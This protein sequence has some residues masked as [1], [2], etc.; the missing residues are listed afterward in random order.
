MGERMVRLTVDM[1]V[2]EGQLDK[3]MSIAETMTAGCRKS[4][5]RWGTI[6][7]R[8]ATKNASG[9]WKLTGMPMPCSRTLRARLCRSW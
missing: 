6:G 8:A 1:T 9:W 4:P 2:N 7:F 5:A 3:F